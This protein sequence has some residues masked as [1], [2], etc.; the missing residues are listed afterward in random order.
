MKEGKDLPGHSNRVFCVKY[1]QFDSNQVASGGWD[2]TVQI[3]DVRKKE[4]VASMWGPHVC[5][6]SIDFR[7][8]GNTVLTGSYR[9]SNVLELWDLRTFKKFK[10]YEWDGP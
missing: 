4:P 5:G 2:D 1:N 8:D 9:Q 3:Y 10:T 6:D 7:N